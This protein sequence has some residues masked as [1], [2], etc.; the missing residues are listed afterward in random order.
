MTKQQHL[1]VLVRLGEALPDDGKLAKD[2]GYYLVRLVQLNQ[3]GRWGS[4][5]CCPREQTSTGL[6]YGNGLACEYSER[7]DHRLE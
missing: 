2:H 1:D 5:V 3:Y 7:Y 4:C 6:W